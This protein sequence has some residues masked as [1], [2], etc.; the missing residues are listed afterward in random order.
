[1][2]SLVVAIGS[3]PRITLQTIMGLLIYAIL[4]T[5]LSKSKVLSLQGQNA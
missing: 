5:V 1:M 2:I 3:I 4:A